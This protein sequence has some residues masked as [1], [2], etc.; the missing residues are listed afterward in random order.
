MATQ[1][2]YEASMAYSHT[3]TLSLETKQGD[4]VQVD[5]RQLFAQYQSYQQQ[6]SSESGPQ[7]ARLFESREAMEATA[8]E[9]RFG[10]AVQGT[11]NEEE[12]QAIF[13]VF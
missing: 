2:Q 3:M 13:K 1:S 12:T 11:L 6:Q 10:F 7:G 8:F 5:F 4:S 9:E